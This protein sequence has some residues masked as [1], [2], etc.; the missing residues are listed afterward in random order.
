MRVVLDTNV[1]VSG[2]LWRGLPWR[3]LRLA[4]DSQVTPCLAP[5]M[6]DELAEVLSYQRLQP[7]LQRLGLE[8]PDLVS[9]AIGLALLFDVPPGP[10]LVFSDPDDDIFLRCAAVAGASY[11]VSGDQHLLA[12]ERHAGFPIVTVHDFLATE[13]PD[14]LDAGPSAGK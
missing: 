13:F 10:I 8:V 6:L 5:E 1:W 9:Y 7:R 3:V 11:I 4:E 2:L 12:T 14:Q